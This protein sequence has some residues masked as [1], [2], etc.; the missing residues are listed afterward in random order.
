MFVGDA[1]YVS[2]WA[3]EIGDA[4]V[5]RRLLNQPVVLY[6][7]SDGKAAA[8]YDS[9]CHRGAPLSFGTV[10]PKASSAAIMGSYST[11]RASASISL[12]RR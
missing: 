2:A 4:P 5:A 10:V 7:D 12:A 1:W 3:D 8:L 9:C 11:R 6:R